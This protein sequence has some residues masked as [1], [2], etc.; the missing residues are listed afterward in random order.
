MKDTFEEQ[1]DNNYQY[2]DQLQSE[3]TTVILQ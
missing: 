3:T 2:L 1:N